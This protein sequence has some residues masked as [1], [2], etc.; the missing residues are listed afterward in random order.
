METWIAHAARH[1]GEMCVVL[2][3]SGRAETVP[4]RF[5]IW[6]QENYED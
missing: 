4:I 2:T 6:R 1:R 5:R 3:E